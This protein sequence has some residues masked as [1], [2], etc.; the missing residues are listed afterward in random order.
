MSSRGNSQTAKTAIFV[1]GLLIVCLAAWWLVPWVPGDTGNRLFVAFDL[2][3]LYAVAFVPPLLLPRLQQSTTGR[4]VSVGILYWGIG[5]YAIYTVV[6]IWRACSQAF[7]PTRLLVIL[8]LVGLFALVGVMYF[9]TTTREH[10]DAVEAGEDTLMRNVEH[11][12]SQASSTAIDASTLGDAYAQAKKKIEQISEEVRYLSPVTSPQACELEDH[13]Y[14]LQGELSG[15]VQA[16]RNGGVA[17]Q[18]LSRKADDVLLVIRQRKALI[19]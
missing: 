18:E 11:I 19:N 12:R 4:I 10:A 6:L 14:R 7:P 5:L 17:P 9:S 13:L 3:L 16:A 15:L 8:Q 2:V 1:F